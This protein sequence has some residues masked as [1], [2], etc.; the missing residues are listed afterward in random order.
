MIVKQSREVLIDACVSSFG[1]TIVCLLSVL[2]ARIDYERKPRPSMRRL[3]RYQLVRQLYCN[4]LCS[5]SEDRL[6]RDGTKPY[7][8][9]VSRMLKTRSLFE[10][11]VCS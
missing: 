11:S 4:L 6:S 3:E 1:P 10:L 8:T 7:C 9:S 2:L 5:K